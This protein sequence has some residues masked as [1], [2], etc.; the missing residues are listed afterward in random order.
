MPKGKRFPRQQETAECKNDD[1]NKVVRAEVMIAPGLLGFDTKATRRT[2]AVLWPQ[3]KSTHEPPASRPTP[4]PSSAS[5]SSFG[6][7]CRDG[8][9][10]RPAAPK[11]PAALARQRGES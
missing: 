9:R 11:R 10:A 8:A 2:I 6:A 3:P 4:D 5:A 1:Q 7:T